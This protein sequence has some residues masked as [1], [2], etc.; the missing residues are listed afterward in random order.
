M[1]NN[2]VGQ[3]SYYGFGEKESKVYLTTLELSS[4]LASTIARRAEVNRSTTYS[5]LEDLKRKWIVTEVTR[6]DVK[7]YSAI[8]PDILFKKREEKYEKIK[9]GLPELLAVTN[10]FGN[11]PR[12]QFFEWFEWLKQV[13]EEVLLAWETM[14]DSYLS[15]VWADKMDPKVEKYIYEEF[16][17]RRIKIKTKTKAIMSKDNSEYVK[18]HKKSH[19]TIIVDKP[20]FNLGN[21]IV[22]FGE[23]KVAVLM[24][25]TEEM[26][27]LIIES[28]TLHD[29]LKSL[30]NL[31]WDVYK[32][33][34]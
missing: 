20:L 23:N 16:V 11:R 19:N 15:F 27:G 18:Y 2:L 28:Q 4:S 32:S 25:A 26:S 34:K 29:G 33:K 8:S 13:F 3:L 6:D 12:T 5:I 7:Y 17:P 9:S 22:V 31:V 1:D 21:E 10:K 14:S 30:F 24:Y